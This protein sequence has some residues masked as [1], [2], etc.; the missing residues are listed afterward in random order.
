MLV[1]FRSTATESITMFSDVAQTLLK[2][3]GATG[4]IPGGFNPEDVPG[5]LAKLERALQESRAQ[6]ARTAAPPAV[7]EDWSADDA[8]R[9]EEEQKEPPVSI[10]TRAVPLVSLLKR[11]AAANAEVI[12]EA[13]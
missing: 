10:G 12:W 1:I 4:K 2:L 5:A 3:M 9:D 7:N 11:A 8:D 13:R 6:P